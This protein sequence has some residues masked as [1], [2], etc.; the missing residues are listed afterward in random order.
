MENLEVPSTGQHPLYAIQSPQEWKRYR[1]LVAS[2]L[3]QKKKVT[4][5]NDA[6]KKTP[7]HTDRLTYQFLDKT[8]DKIEG[9]NI[10]SPEQQQKLNPVTYWT[11]FHTD[12]V[13]KALLEAQ[14]THGLEPVAP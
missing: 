12:G 6:I 5:L 9:S 11:L 1:K 8:V 14:S 7:Q 2:L 3:K 10:W 13:N 4:D